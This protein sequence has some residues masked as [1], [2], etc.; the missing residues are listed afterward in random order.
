MPGNSII[1]T[2][3]G[4]ITPLRTAFNKAAQ[5]AKESAREQASAYSEVHRAQME[6]LKTEKLRAQAAGNNEIAA[7]IQEEITLR[8]EA[9]RLAHD[10][11]IAEHEAVAIAQERLALN[12]KIA[13][14]ARE[15][16]RQGENGP[17]G[18][19][20]GA[21]GHGGGMSGR[22]IGDLVNLA[23][24]AQGAV[25]EIG[26]L[27]HALGAPLALAAGAVV[28][29]KVV[30][31]LKEAVH[32]LN[33]AVNEG[34]KLSFQ[35]ISAQVAAG[36]EAVKKAVEEKRAAIDKIRESRGVLAMAGDAIGSL[37]G[38]T[39]GRTSLKIRGFDTGLAGGA[40]QRS[41]RT[42]LELETQ[43]NKA[44]LDSSKL[45]RGNT[46]A[47]ESLIHASREELELEINKQETAKRIGEIRNN[48]GSSAANI[49]AE[50]AAEEKEGEK[51][52]REIRAR[53][54]ATR[55]QIELER[56]LTKIHAA[57]FRE[58]ERSAAK[59]LDIAK[60]ELVVARTMGSDGVQ[61]AET[62][63]AAAETEHTL[64]VR[65]GQEAR[66]QIAMQE[67]IADLIAPDNV[68]R[69]QELS[70]Q[71]QI[72]EDQIKTARP[73]E[74]A[75]LEADLADNSAEFR[76]LN[77]FDIEKERRIEDSSIDEQT[78]RGEAEQILALQR[79]VRVGLA[80]VK[81][82]E[83]NPA[84]DPE[85]V[86]AQRV[87]VHSDSKEELNLTEAKERGLTV[88]RA[89]TQI[90]SLQGQH[91]RVLAEAL[92]IQL[93]YAQRIAQARRDGNTELV[94]ELQKQK[95]VALANQ[96]K[97]L[98]LR[99]QDQ[100]KFSLAE[101][102]EEGRGGVGSKARRIA[103]QE[104]LGRK[105]ALAGDEVG[106]LKHFDKANKLKAGFKPLARAEQMTAKELTGAFDQST[107]AKSLQGIDL[108]M[109][110]IDQNAP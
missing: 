110:K 76:A 64:S 13:E 51:R 66:A 40:I 104:E 74:R 11:G 49:G 16:A 1:A 7:A 105:R 17:D 22:R 9:V 41:Y 102:A 60:K 5:M 23:T 89:E 36:P 15:A 87:K 29:V 12:R 75:K 69:R 43:I 106:A 101:L 100:T 65:R 55:Y 67:R 98:A 2:F 18:P 30:E 94:A 73:D 25:N 62:A 27:Q 79:K 92:R 45:I 81:E 63:V 95:E 96:Q 14:A 8:T 71:R 28:A 35:N 58:E 57:G 20:N 72:I 24:G 21:G 10:L 42:Q 50:V 54:A 88:T 61:A 53:G 34:E 37:S 33:E 85:Q 19:P 107:I 78:G 4:D 56:D 44:T 31:K 86:A 26:L 48:A 59:R 3:G 103:R 32:E 83:N 99:R 93:D 108:K 47:R 91:Q 84:L 82:D 80:R 6:Q 90:L 39:D 109:D 77:R 52:N 38:H 97:E 68:K 70:G 46:A